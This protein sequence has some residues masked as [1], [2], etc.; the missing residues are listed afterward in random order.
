M[1]GLASELGDRLDSDVGHH[2]HGDPFPELGPGRR[3]VHARDADPH[4]V[5][6]VG[7][8]QKKQPADHND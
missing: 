6:H 4:L 2:G 8:V 3:P 1:P 5:E 7:D